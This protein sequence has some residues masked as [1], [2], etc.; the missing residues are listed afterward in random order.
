MVRVKHADRRLGLRGDDGV[1]LV[2]KTRYAIDK[3]GEVDVSEA[4]ARMM[5][6]GRKWEAIRQT[7]EPTPQPVAPPEQPKPEPP[8]EEP[9]PEDED[10]DQLESMDRDSLIR[11]AEDLSV[12]IDKRWST[13]RIVAAIKAARE[14]G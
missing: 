2:G 9:E 1:V 14:E 8:L 10:A 5:L 13:V 6:Q 11:L 7:G 4:D 3:N 12:D